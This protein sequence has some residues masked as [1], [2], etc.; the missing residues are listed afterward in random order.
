M[1]FVKR[2]LGKDG[3]P[4]DYGKPIESSWGPS[5]QYDN[6][7]SNSISMDNNGHCVEVHVVPVSGRPYGDFFYRVGTVDFVNKTISWGASTQYDN[8]GPNSIAMD[9]NGHCIEVH[10][11]SERL[12]YRVGTVNFVNK[13]ISWGPSTQYDNG[14]SNSIS[15]DNNGHCVEVHVV[16][17]SGRPYGDFFYRVGTVD[18]VNKTISWGASTQYDNGGSNSIAM[19]NNGRCI[20]VHVGSER[21]FYRVGTVNFVNKAISWGPSTQYDNGESNSISMDNNGHCVEVHVVPVSGR[22]YGDFFYRVGTVDFVNKTISWGAS[23]QYDNGGP[24]SIA[25]DNNG[26]CIEVHVGSERLFYRVNNLII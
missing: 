26:R 20:E 16:P 22:P 18:F 8:G 11:G 15:M 24:N 14:E 10:I 1:E 3:I 13:A 2:Y 21:L 4:L 9:N 5:T 6:G 12:F 25:M 7:E 17:V 19:D 23:T